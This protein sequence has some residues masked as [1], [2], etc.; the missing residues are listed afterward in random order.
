[1]RRIR[2]IS[3]VT[4]ILFFAGAIFPRNNIPF[5]QGRVPRF[6][7]YP[8][9]VIQTSR[10]IPVDAGSTPYTHCFRTMLRGTAR[11][12]VKFAGRYALSYWGCGSECARIGIVNLR[13]GRSYVSPFWVTGV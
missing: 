11:R 10:S 9:K 1:M 4:L 3:A 7:D 5:T 8:S 13:T 6:T 2:G 12:G